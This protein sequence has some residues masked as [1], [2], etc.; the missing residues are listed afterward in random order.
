MFGLIRFSAVAA[1]AFALSGAAQAQTVGF[2]TL[3]P[4]A[5]NNI[6]VQGMSKVVQKNSGLRMRV[7][8]FRGTE[9]VMR[10]VDGKKAE[11]GISEAASLTA[12]LTG[13][14]GSEFDGQPTKN[15]RVALRLRPILIGMFVRKDSSIKT[16]A[17]IKGKRYP[18]GWS[19]FPN[20]IPLSLGIM[21]TEGL[22]FK[23]IKG[24]PVTNIIRGADDFKAGKLDIGFFALGA[25]KMQ[26]VNSAV[27]GIR[28]LSVRKTP[29]SLKAM[30]SIRS[31]YYIATVKPSPVMAG[32][33]GPTNV[34]AVAT[35]IL[36]G[37]HVAN[38]VVGKFV[39]AVH[40]NKGEL[41]KGHPLFRAYNPKLMGKKLSTAKYHPGAIAY[42]KKNGIWPGS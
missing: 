5:I 29:A 16:V 21:A 34:L 1:A 14:K 32:V 39:A 3:P 17:D 8:P 15:L 6:T 23:D 42:Y 35:L 26:E 11:F 30:R 38:D 10:A 20:S 27:G 4:G 12:G 2:A 25:P 37:T 28:W 18:S 36:V 22:T 24:V 41:V 33:A 9:A 7:I 31:E 13:M 19:Q 40:D